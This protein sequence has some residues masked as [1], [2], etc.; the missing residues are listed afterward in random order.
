[1]NEE[2]FYLCKYLEAKQAISGSN[3]NANGCLNNNNQKTVIGYYIRH[4]LV[5]EKYL[6]VEF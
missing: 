4:L 3:L 2:I 6:Q 5:Q 1:L